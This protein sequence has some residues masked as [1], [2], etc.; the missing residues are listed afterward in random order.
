[1]KKILTFILAAAL[2]L[3]LAACGAPSEPDPGSPTPPPYLGKWEASISMEDGTV[4]KHTLTLGINGNITY[5]VTDTY[6]GS[7]VHE[8]EYSFYDWTEENY[9]I[10]CDGGEYIMVLLYDAENDTITAKSNKNIIYI[11]AK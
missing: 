3:S 10:T 1:M 2:L 7:T 6:F 9:E 11:R 8:E 4:A 5:Y